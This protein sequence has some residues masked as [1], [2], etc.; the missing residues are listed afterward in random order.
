MAKKI[1]YVCSHCGSNE[2]L[3]DA[4]A[5]WNV[6][7]QKWELQNTFDKGAYCNQCDGEARLEEKEIE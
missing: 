7:E 2:V 3:C 6:E 1:D 5:E 4:Y